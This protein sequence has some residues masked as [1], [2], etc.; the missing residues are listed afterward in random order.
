MMTMVVL[1]LKLKLLFF[2]PARGENVI[3][4]SIDSSSLFSQGT[5]VCD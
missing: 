5:D 1:G 3:L 4:K 2:V